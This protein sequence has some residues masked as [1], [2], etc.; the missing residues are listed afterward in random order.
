MRQ[1]SKAPA[2]GKLARRLRSVRPSCAPLEERVLLSVTLQASKSTVSPVGA[3]ITWT[4]SAKGHGAR[5]VYQFL[6]ESSAGETQVVRDFSPT[7]TFTW[8]PMVEGNYVFR[9]IVKNS[10]GDTTTETT[11]TAHRARSRA[12]AGRA[13]VNP[14]TNPLVALYSAPAT[15]Q[16]GTMRVEFRPAG[17]NRPWTSTSDQQVVAGRSTNVIVAGMLPNTTYSIRSV[18]SD[19]R[20]SAALPF[21]TGSLP[22]DVRFPTF[23][24][25]K[26]AGARSGL[27]SQLVFHMGVNPAPGSVNTLATDLAGNIVWYYDPVSNNYPGYAQTLVSGGTVMMLG[28]VQTPGGGTNRLRE[29]DLAGNTLRETSVPAMNAQLA[30]KGLPSIV[31][32]NHEARVLPDGRTAILAAS[33]R[34]IDIDG[35]PTLYNGD[36]ILVLDQNFQLAWAWDPFRWLDPKRLPTAGELPTDWTHANTVAWSPADGNLIMSL[37]AQDWVIKVDYDHGAGDGHIVWRLGEGGD[38]TM[39]SAAASPWFT[40]QHDPRY[41][42]DST[43]AVFDNGNTRQTTLPGSNSRGQVLALDEKNM[44]AT[45]TV[46][47]DLGAYAPAVGSSQRLADGSLVYNAGF[48]KQ[49]I[50]VRPDGSRFYIL[51]M[52]MKGLQY[53]SYIYDTLYVNPTDFL[54]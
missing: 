18:A 27:N 52:A 23:T 21:R 4:A 14:L 36:M 45:L 11:G 22:S 43:I 42:D 24:L 3:P 40:H 29:V 19:G 16:D 31:D 53:R 41:I 6:V 15:S 35:T 44:V 25:Q 48:T 34:M 8:A 46:N 7:R 54:A 2:Q 5:P 13:V 9:V 51:K 12:Q 10:Y 47:A 28:G 37:R 50:A 33:H 39:N 17:T 38:F 1:L 30:A 26:P 49:T 20:V 32:F